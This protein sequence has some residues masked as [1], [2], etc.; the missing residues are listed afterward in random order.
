MN[1]HVVVMPVRTN[2]HM[3][4]RAIESCLRQSIDG[5]VVLN[6]I[7]NGSDDGCGPYLR[8]LQCGIILQ[9]YATPQNLHRIWNQSIR[10]AFGRLGAEHVLVVNNDIV[11]RPDTYRLLLEDGGLFVTGIGVDTIEGTYHA[12]PSAR[13]P[14]P[15][16]SCFLIRRECWDRVGPFEE[17]YHIYYGDN[18]YHVRMHRAGIDARQIDVPFYHVGSGTLK[19]V[20]PET[21]EKL[22][23]LSDEDKGTFERQYGCLPTTEAYDRLFHPDS[24][25][26]IRAVTS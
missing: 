8:S 7:D 15:S 13:S 16:F 1:A 17:T 6:V 11:L 25:G 10:L 20:N 2:V 26:S 4:R 23:R 24:F 3:T 9:T 5:G 22:F 14:H 18:S 12:N 19:S 21:R